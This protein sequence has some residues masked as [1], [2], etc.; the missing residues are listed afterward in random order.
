MRANLTALLRNTA[1]RRTIAHHWCSVRTVADFLFGFLS[2]NPPPPM[3]SMYSRTCLCIQRPLQLN[4]VHQTTPLR[5]CGSVGVIL[6]RP[7]ACG[8]TG[9]PSG[10]PILEEI[11]KA[12]SDEEYHALH[13][14]LAAIEQRCAAAA[15]PIV[16]AADLL[17]SLQSR[18]AFMGVLTRNSKAN[19]LATLGNCRFAHY[20]EGFHVLGR[21]ESF[22]K[23]NPDGI[24]YV[25]ALRGASC[26]RFLIVVLLQ[27]QSPPSPSSVPLHY[28]TSTHPR[29][30][31]KGC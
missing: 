5:L 24:L 18:G 22:P 4:T 9:L 31:S 30:L 6:R 3:H 10:S 12:E 27:P 21:D 25:F 29:V 15:V 8:H 16:G 20:F 26:A 13:A 17:E 14:T 19:A 7:C 23:P 2:Y 11:N 28:W 1:C